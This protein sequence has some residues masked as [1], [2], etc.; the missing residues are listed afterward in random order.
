M[1][2]RSFLTGSGTTDMEVPSVWRPYSKLDWFGKCGLQIGTG[3]TNQRQFVGDGLGGHR[4]CLEDAG[5]MY[6]GNTT[7]GFYGLYYYPNWQADKYNWAG[8]HLL[9]EDEQCGAHSQL[10]RGATATSE[11]HHQRR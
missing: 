3:K 10:T 6:M 2:L 9:L 5:C 11:R 7:A 8:C 4:D 1:L